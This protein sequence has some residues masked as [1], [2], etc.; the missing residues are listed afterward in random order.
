ML[1]YNITDATVYVNSLLA[2]LNARSSLREKD[3]S[4]SSDGQ[5]ASES[6]TGMDMRP[7]TLH[8]AMQGRS[9]GSSFGTAT[10]DAT[11]TTERYTEDVERNQHHG[12]EHNHD[13]LRRRN[14][15]T[16]DAAAAAV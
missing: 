6:T 4:Y 16:M 5:T 7:T 13:P 10:K 8:L 3:I 11:R 2:S 15:V 9:L 14:D 1:T 12:D